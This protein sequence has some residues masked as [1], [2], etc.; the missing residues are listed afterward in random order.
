[1][2]INLQR[3]FTLIE[4]MIVVAIVGI[5]AAIAVP[6][7]RD[8]TIRARVS[9]LILA[10]SFAKTCAAEAIAQGGSV[11][12]D[13]ISAYCSFPAVGKVSEASV[14]GGTG[15]G[16]TVVGNPSA[17]GAAVTVVLAGSLQ[18][19]GKVLSWNCSG[20]PARYLPASCKG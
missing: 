14:A 9:E 13:N 19:G 10:G 3:G 6:V 7:Y 8:Y 16:I 17:I 11:V 5:L 2:V 4:L 15:A 1:M 12:P 18:A 20:T